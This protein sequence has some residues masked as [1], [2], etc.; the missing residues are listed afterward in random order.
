MPRGTGLPTCVFPS[1]SVLNRERSYGFPRNGSLDG[2]IPDIDVH[3][4]KN[5]VGAVLNFCRVPRYREVPR[6]VVGLSDLDPRFGALLPVVPGIGNFQHFPGQT[7]FRQFLGQKPLVEGFPQT[8]G[9]GILPARAC[10]NNEV[11][12]PVV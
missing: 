3:Q 7:Q 2:A 9:A 10:G 5:L 12:A 11:R 4:A 1:S 8:D 6:L